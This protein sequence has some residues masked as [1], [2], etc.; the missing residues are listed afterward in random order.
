MS[1]EA[2]RERIRGI[3]EKE[4]GYVVKKWVMIGRGKYLDSLLKLR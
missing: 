4:F 1:E 2:F 3:L